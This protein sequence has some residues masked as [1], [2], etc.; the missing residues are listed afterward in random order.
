MS[1]SLPQLR[2][3]VAVAE[4]GSF[5]RAATALGISQS[6]VSHAVSTLERALG[7]RVVTRDAPARLTPLG[8]AVLPHARQ[9]VS[10][11]D[12]LAAAARAHHGVASG[13][14]RLGAVTTAC[15]GLV[16]SLLA[17]WSG[18]LPDVRIEV[19]EGDDEELPVWLE[20]DLVDAAI[21]VDP[22]SIREQDRVLAR[23]SLAALV[24]TDHPLADEP[25]FPVA[26]LAADGFICSVG[27]CLAQIRRL[28][29]QAGVD[30]IV[31][32]SVRELATIMSMVSQGLGVSAIPTI[33]R[34]AL[35][36]E[37][38]LVPLDHTVVRTLV[39]AGPR[40][41]TAHPLVGTIDDALTT[42]RAPD[43]ARSLT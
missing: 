15:Q 31:R 16:P 24:R 8:S 41:R 13:T 17:H 14:L 30:L 1:L 2:A 32:Q 37:L 43:H 40:S 3:L 38:M 18:T 21:L 20:D 11:A 36:A 39:L 5:S 12:A 19:F 34:P 33:V 10:S 22:E 27:G 42:W 28:H 26:E 35:P 29:E 4:H 23:D 25:V 7:D 6:A 9:T